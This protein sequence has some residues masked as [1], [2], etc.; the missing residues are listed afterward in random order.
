MDACV[1][2]DKRL[3]KMAFNLF[4]PNEI[5]FTDIHS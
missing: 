1:V 2:G 5:D 3:L 4:K